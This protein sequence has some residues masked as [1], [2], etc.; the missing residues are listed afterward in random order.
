MSNNNILDSIWELPPYAAFLTRIGA[1]S[2]SFTGAVIKTSHAPAWASSN[3]PRDLITLSLNE[4]ALPVIRAA[5]GSDSDP[6]EYEPTPEE[7]VAM[8]AAYGSSQR[9]NSSFVV[10]EADI[11][12]RIL[13]EGYAK[14]DCYRFM[15][16]RRI[17]GR[18][19]LVTVMIEARKTVVVDGEELKKVRRF[20]YFD[21]GVWRNADPEGFLPIY[22]AHRIEAG[23]QVVIHEG[24]KAAAVAQAMADYSLSIKRA[25]RS[26]QAIYDAHPWCH[27]FAG[28]VHV[29]FAGGAHSWHRADWSILKTMGATAAYCMGDNDTVG[30]SAMN[31]V[32]R[33]IE[34][35]PVYQFAW[36]GKFPPS[37]D[38]G[39]PFPETAI[40]ATHSLNFRN[41][42]ELVTPPTRV[43]MIENDKGELKPKRV[44]NPDW[45]QSFIYTSRHGQFFLRNNPRRTYD[46]TALVNHYQFGEH[47]LK[48]NDLAV[49]VKAVANR[50]RLYDVIWRPMDYVDAS[51]SS[52][53]SRRVRDLASGHMLFNSYMGTP[54]RAVAGDIGPFM[55]FANH[56]IPDPLDRAEFLR[57][58]ATLVG[59]ASRHL[60]YAIILASSLGSTGK[61]TY[62]DKVLL[63]LVGTENVIST[64]PKAMFENH[65]AW[66]F[67][68]R[69]VVINE[70]EV[71]SHSRN[72]MEDLFKDFITARQTRGRKMYRDEEQIEVNVAFAV[73]DNRRVPFPI[74]ASDRRWFMPQV[75]ESVFTYERFRAFESWLNQGGY[76]FILNWAC[77]A[78]ADDPALE[79]AFQAAAKELTALE[80]SGDEAGLEAKRLEL[81]Q[82][83]RAYVQE[84][85]PAPMSRR[86]R[87][88]IEES[89]SEAQVT[90]SRLAGMVA[91]KAEPAAITA[92][93]AKAWLDSILPKANLKEATIKEALASSGLI[94]LNA[95]KDN[96]RVDLS[97]SDRGHYILMNASLAAMKPKPS[98]LKNHVVDPADMMSM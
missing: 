17:D 1:E 47:T 58:T 6:S 77:H 49:G 92:K 97:P 66:R 21:D 53:E 81:S 96:P 13:S 70:F 11:P 12:A 33:R 9:P 50:E 63:P 73:S 8:I 83:P 76:G 62:L 23:C 14:A 93:G 82:M 34:G 2:R 89:K 38:A 90:L 41:F 39:D 31:G 44:C 55:E 67:E 25:S 56:L 46:A 3:S 84:G 98:V 35:M 30:I 43:V 51:K 15:E 88:W 65:N 5:Y 61:T 4:G 20:T 68:K 57:W 60:D 85:E 95:H 52:Y 7:K 72:E 45:A 29:A 26:E 40:E 94:L 22:N 48:G 24:P 91:S 18:M 27:E 36:D 16:H 87:Q 74:S 75:T 10:G 69:L 32:S 59:K 54:I 86:K 80:A 37:W 79:I 28:Y 64:Q 42:F 78:Y 71:G 19:M